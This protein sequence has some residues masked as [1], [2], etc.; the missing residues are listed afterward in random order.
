M[1]NFCVRCK[2]TTDTC[3]LGIQQSLGEH[4]DALRTEKFR[5]WKSIPD[6]VQS[7]SYQVI[8]P[9]IRNKTN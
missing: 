9:H 8:K 6:R 3:I 7:A 2:A 4:L 1:L 5:K